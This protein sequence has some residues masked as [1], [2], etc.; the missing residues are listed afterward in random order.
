MVSV[1]VS[2]RRRSVRSKLNFLLL[3]K[4]LHEPLPESTAVRRCLPSQEVWLLAWAE[5]E[6]ERTLQLRQAVQKLGC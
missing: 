1:V 3:I 2:T 4:A 5:L 6:L